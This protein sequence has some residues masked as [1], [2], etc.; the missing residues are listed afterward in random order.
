V[1]DPLRYDVIVIGVG[2]MGSST[3]YY[4]AK[5]G[6]KILGFEQFDIPNELSS[7]TGQ[8]RIIRKAYYE[9]P[10]YVPL[11]ERAYADWADLEAASGQQVYFKTGLLYASKPEHP[12]LQGVKDSA[13]TYH[14]KLDQFSEKDKTTRY[15]ILKT[16]ADYEILFEPDAGFITPENAIN[17]YVE[18]AKQ[19]GAVI[20]S[21]VKVESWRKVNSH[22]E[23]NTSIGTYTAE[24]LIFT[25]GPWAAKLLPA[26]KS[27]LSI[28]KQVLA[29]VK[30]RNSSPFEL[31]QFPCWMIADDHYPGVFYGFP[32]LPSANFDGPTGFKLAHHYPGELTD[33][34]FINRNPSSADE[35]LL[36]QFMQRYFPDEY[37]STIEMKTCMY[38]NSPDEH[39]ILDFL[40]GYDQD[41]MVATGFSGH[42]FKFASVIGEI[43]SDLAIKGKTELPIEFLRLKRF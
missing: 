24:K 30:T 17:A 4:L 9:H 2:S 8:S 38:T 35:H 5:A 21:K 27:T 34:D 36:V 25:A 7:H 31:G 14:I 41:V 6:I 16:P 39:F 1:N 23:V 26:L 12:I 32:I 29:W 3:C 20:T 11:L 37:I 42:G 13:N 19:H 22:F 40:P 18:L 15:P 10:D 33:P 43:M 28:T